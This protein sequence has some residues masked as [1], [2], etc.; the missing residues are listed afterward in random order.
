[1][2]IVLV[3][4]HP[5]TREGLRLLLERETGFVVVGTAAHAREAFRQVD[6][7]RPEVVVMSLS[8][9]GM[10]GIAATREVK[11]RRGDARILATGACITEREVLDVLAAGATG[12]VD[13]GDPVEAFLGGIRAVG[14]ARPFLGPSIRALALPPLADGLPRPGWAG[15]AHHVLEVLSVREREVFELIVRG[16]KNREVGRELCISS[17]TVE[18]HRLHINRKLGCSSALDL[19]H[20]ALKN[21]LLPW[22][23][24]HRTPD[25]R[26]LPARAV[27]PG[28]MAA[29]ADALHAAG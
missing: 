16:F 3:D 15:R 25:D 7:A 6:V 5:V 14:A 18:T 4:R 20:F 2:R 26:A 11:R 23:E 19:M 28:A 24:V 29:E 27:A 12:V 13:L 9:P 10:S 21:D 1:M 8:L 22:P 17:K